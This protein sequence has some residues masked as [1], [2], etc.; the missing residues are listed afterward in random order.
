MT[1]YNGLPHLS[2]AIDSILA[3]TF[4]SFELVIIDDAGTDGSVA[5]IERYHDPRIRLVRNERNL[6]QTRSLNRGLE[7]VR[8]AYVARMDQDDVCLPERF[9]RQVEVLDQRAAVAAVG[10]WM[11]GMDRDGRRLGMIGERIDA[12]GAFLGLLLIGGCPLCHPSVMFRRDAIQR[13]G[14]YDESMAHTEDYDL[15]SRLAVSGARAFVIPEPLVM[16]RMHGGQQSVTRAAAHHRNWYRAHERLVAAFCDPERARAVSL[17]LR[18]EATLRSEVPSKRQLASTFKA[19]RRMLVTISQR[20]QLSA[21]EARDLTRAIGRRLGPVFWIGPSFDR[22]PEFLFQPM[23]FLFMPW[24]VPSVRRLLSACAVRLRRL[25]GM[26]R[27]AS[28]G[29]SRR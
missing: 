5:C 4:T 25:R 1:V 2:A 26:L 29:L 17:L 21:E 23:L 13:L 28:D 19:L 8:A 14:G 3:Q 27:L 6:G 20:L 11:Y 7:F 10:T 18:M 16:Y 24:S 15:W 9:A 12:Y 22:C